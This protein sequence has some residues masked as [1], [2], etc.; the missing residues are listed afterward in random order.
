MGDVSAISI[1]PES[2]NILV[3]YSLPPIQEEAA[4]SQRKWQAP[5]HPLGCTEEDNMVVPWM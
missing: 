2:K 1:S 3:S 5:S 4:I